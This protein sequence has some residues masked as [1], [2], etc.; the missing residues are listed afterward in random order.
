MAQ[1]YFLYAG[2]RYDITSMP[3]R[4]ATRAVAERYIQKV[5]HGF[6]VTKELADGWVVG[7]I[8]ARAKGRR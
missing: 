4:F 2:H 8:V 5:Y 1:T 7:R 6:G 3:K